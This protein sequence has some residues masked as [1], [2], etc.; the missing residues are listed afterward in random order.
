M[1]LYLV[2]I[3][4]VGKTTI[5]KMLAK[6]IDFPFFDLDIEIQNYYNFKSTNQRIRLWIFSFKPIQY[7]KVLP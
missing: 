7:E 1:I 4:C 2:G 3:S 5:G 6:N